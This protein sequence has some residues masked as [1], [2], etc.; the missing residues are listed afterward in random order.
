MN[1]SPTIRAVGAVMVGA[2]V[3]IVAEYAGMPGPLST[4]VFILVVVGLYLVGDI[5]LTRWKQ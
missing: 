3:M 4:G 1:Y 5:S 2:G